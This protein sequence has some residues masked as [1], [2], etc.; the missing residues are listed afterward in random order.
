MF[1]KNNDKVTYEYLNQRFENFKN[2]EIKQIE[3]DLKNLTQL[4]SMLISE[5]G[6]SANM[7]RGSVVTLTKI[8]NKK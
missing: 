5:L 4:V 7:Q 1:N 2:W 3:D 6:Y 8:S